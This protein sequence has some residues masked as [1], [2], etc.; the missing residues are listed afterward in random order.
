MRACPFIEWNTCNRYK[1]EANTVQVADSTGAGDAFIGCFL[2]QIADIQNPNELFKDT[3]L[4][5]KMVKN[6]NKAGAITTT[7]YGA[8][9]SLPACDEV[10]W[11]FRNYLLIFLKIEFS[12]I[13]K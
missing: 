10:F 6:S 7:N 9:S 5:L 11:F 13:H 1:I 8:I 3:S 12:V 2:K 4:L